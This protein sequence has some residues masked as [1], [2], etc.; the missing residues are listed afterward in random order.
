MRR[1]LRA[2][3]LLC[4]MALV[5][6]AWSQTPAEPESVGTPQEVF[7]PGAQRPCP[8]V[9]IAKGFHSGWGRDARH[10]AGATLVI[11]HPDAW[12]V[13]WRIHCNEPV[14][15]PPVDFRH[16]VVIAAIQG[17]QR[18]TVGPNI[19]I[20]AVEAEGPFARVVVVDDPRSGPEPEMS[21]PFHIV[22]TCRRQ[23]PGRASVVVQRVRPIP[24]SGVV[25]GRIFADR[26]DGEPVPLGGAHV[27]LLPREGEPRGTVSGMDGS[28][29]FVN[30][31]PGEY[32]LRAEHPDFEPAELA[33][34]VPPE[35]LV[36]HDLLLF[37]PPPPETGA[38]VGRVLGQ[39][40]EDRLIPIPG[41]LVRLLAGD[42]VVAQAET[43]REGR[44][45]MRDVPPG[46]YRAVAE[47]EGW[48]PDDAEVEIRPGERTRHRFVLQPR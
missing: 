19:S 28:Y 6:V 14:P 27:M 31:R 29:F 42:E 17:P 3:A 16:E 12:E 43:N 48:L 20:V 39:I 36:I 33:I 47:A 23:L 35:T 22:K 25:V 41:A 21:N 13:F 1:V 34:E 44:F 9:T 32:L 2:G 11:R 45:A 40:E 18:T 26:P 24:E 5:G 46:V 7:Q 38:F 37:P 4:A 15:P 10:F 8:L 30:V